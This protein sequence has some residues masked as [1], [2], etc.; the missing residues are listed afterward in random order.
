MQTEMLTESRKIAEQFS[1][2]FKKKEIVGIMFIGA[3][4]R[5]Y[6]DKFADIDIIILTIKKVKPR[7]LPVKKY[8]GFHFDAW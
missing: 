4:A 2:K 1:N 8:K 7:G 6:F 5:G 3:L